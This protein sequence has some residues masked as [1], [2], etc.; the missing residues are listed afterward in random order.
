MKASKDK[1]CLKSDQDVL[2]QIAREAELKQCFREKETALQVSIDHLQLQNCELKRNVE[3]LHMNLTKETEMKTNLKSSLALSE[4]KLTEAICKYERLQ[5][6]FISLGDESKN[7]I[8][9]LQV[10]HKSLYEAL[11]KTEADRQVHISQYKKTNE[12]LLGKSRY[13]SVRHIPVF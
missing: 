5:S 9:K 11:Q 8:N 13:N 10:E 7:T 1:L 12:D 6:D 3:E 2:R 4:S